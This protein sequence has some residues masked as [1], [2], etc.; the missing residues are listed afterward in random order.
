MKTKEELCALKE[1]VETLNRKLAALSEEE[2]AQV[3]GG[4]PD[5]PAMMLAAS[6]F[7]CMFVPCEPPV[8]GGSLP[9]TIITPSE[10]DTN[11]EQPALHENL[12]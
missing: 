7:S 10:P 8:P 4:A 12:F 6:G 11:F 1:E 2:L 3:A 9:A 5:L